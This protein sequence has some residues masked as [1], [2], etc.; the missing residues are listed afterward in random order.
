MDV[1]I[2]PD[3]SSEAILLRRIDYGDSDL[4]VTLFTPDAGKLTVIAKAAKKSKKRFPVLEL[5]S[6]LSVV[7]SLSQRKNLPL[8][9][10]AQLHDAFIR[11]RTDI[12]KTGY[13]AYWVELINGWLPEAKADKSLYCLLEEVLAALDHGKISAQM[14]SI[15]FQMKFLDL[16]GLQPNLDT[17]VLCQTRTE[18]LHENTLSV[19]LKEGGF[20][21]CNCAPENAPHS[22]FKLSKGTLKQL[23]WMAQQKLSTAARMRLSAR[24]EKEALDFLESFVP[25]HVGKVPKSLTFLKGLRSCS[26]APACSGEFL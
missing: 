19:S 11:I 14:L 17:C 13:A 10:E 2:M 12:H 15:Y 20:I 4:I 9:K 21:C 16:A 18:C 22:G 7:Y 26:G 24:N 5:F 3:I 1:K 23:L 6:R 25:Y 8:L